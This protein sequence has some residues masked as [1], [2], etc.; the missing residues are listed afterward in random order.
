MQEEPPQQTPA[1]T[2]LEHDP[3][4]CEAW[5]ANVTQAG[6]DEWADLVGG[7]AFETL[8]AT[9]DT[10]DL[11]FLRNVLIYMGLDSRRRILARI[12]QQ[13]APD[14]YLLLG[15]TENLLQ[16]PEGYESVD[17]GGSVFYKPV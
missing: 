13:M 2:S 9:R 8:Q 14:G 6:L 10:F 7:D 15:A 12:R 16:T 1:L 3:V 17:V 5:R 11:V 4:K